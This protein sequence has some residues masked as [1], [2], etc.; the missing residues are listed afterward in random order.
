MSKDRSRQEPGMPVAKQALAQKR[1]VRDLNTRLEMYVRAQNEKTRNVNQLKEALA[2][3]E[4]D[5]RNKLNQQK[6][7][8]QDQIEKSRKQI[9][10]L[11]YD[12]KCIHQ[13]LDTANMLSGKIYHFIMFFRLPFS[14]INYTKKQNINNFLNFLT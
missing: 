7:Q 12:N 13:E 14:K 5:Y 11:A 1:N 4:M 6:L 9:E 10:N 2:R 3:N 8:F